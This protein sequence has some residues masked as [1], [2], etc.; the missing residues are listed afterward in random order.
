MHAIYAVSKH[1]L[2]LL[3][4]ACRKHYVCGYVAAAYGAELDFG[5]LAGD[6][7]FAFDAGSRDGRNAYN[8]AYALENYPSHDYA[9]VN[10][11]VL[12][13][14]ETTGVNALH[15]QC[16]QRYR[17]SRVCLALAWLAL[18]PLRRQAKHIWNKGP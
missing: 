6:A 8:R 16:A 10:G 11:D 18:W 1:N 2:H 9:L 12:K 14:I 13:Q 15:R 17:L 4:S 7:K 5:H 3:D